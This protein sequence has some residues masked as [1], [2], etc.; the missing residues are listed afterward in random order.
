MVYNFTSRNNNCSHCI[1][2]N[3]CNKNDVYYNYNEKNTH[4]KLVYFKLYIIVLKPYILTLKNSPKHN[5]TT[6]K[7]LNINKP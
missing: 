4:Y 5:S 3:N 2:C 6:S 7:L 1:T